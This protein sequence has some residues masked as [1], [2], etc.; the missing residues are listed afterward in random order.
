[1]SGRRGIGE[2][3]D[4]SKPPSHKQKNQKIKGMVD[5]TKVGG[6]GMHLKIC[7][8]NWWMN[9]DNVFSREEV[10]EGRQWGGEEM[11]GGDSIW[12]QIRRGRKSAVDV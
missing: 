10:E 9:R 6:R 12:E 8:A 7:R 11:V 1:M 3:E 4:R 2:D 5:G